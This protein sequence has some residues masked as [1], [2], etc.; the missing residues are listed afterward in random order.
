MSP[1]L[2]TVLE[3][4]Q[5]QLE[6]VDKWVAAGWAAHI[7]DTAHPWHTLNSYLKHEAEF[8]TPSAQG[9]A[10]ALTV[11]RCMEQGE[12]MGRT[13]LELTRRRAVREARLAE[14]PKAS[15]LAKVPQA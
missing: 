8:T 5:E 3:G 11:A 10:L 7:Q 6:G 13:L 1:A 14:M 2:A 15:E 9:A 4:L 12:T